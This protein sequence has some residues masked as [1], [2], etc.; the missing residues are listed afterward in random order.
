[1]KRF[2]SLLLLFTACKPS[3]FF[4]SPNEVHKEKV[5]LYLNNHTKETGEIDIS[6]EENS[7][8]N[9]VYKPYIQFFPEGKTTEEKIRLNEISGYSMGQDY[10]ELKR[11]DMSIDNIYNL[12]FVK[13]LTAEDSKIQLYEL[14]ESGHASPS[15]E[16]RYSYFLSFPTYAQLETLN[17]ASRQVVP[18]F[19]QKMSLFVADCP[20]LANKIRAKEKGYFIPVGSFKTFQRREVFMRII[21]EYN[22]CN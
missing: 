16:S 22:H 17:A 5:V 10:F 21:D 4:I 11:V 12:L 7:S 15:G 2:L 13:R 14:Y 19:D 18:M 3:S 6:L 20:A 9:A 1:M 8:M